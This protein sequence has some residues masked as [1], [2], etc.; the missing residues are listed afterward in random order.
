MNTLTKTLLALTLIAIAFA[1][2]GCG[3]SSGLDDHAEDSGHSESDGHNHGSTEAD[4]HSDAGD[5]HG[6]DEGSEDGHEEHGE[7]VIK[8]SPQQ[9]ERAGV[10]IQPLSGGTITT[11]ITLPAEVGL[12]LDAV[13]HVTP[14]VPG[15]VSEVSGLLGHAVVQ[16]D[17]LAI[18]ES[19]ELGEAKIAYL[20]SVQSKAIA[21]AELNRQRTI[22][23]NT[24]TLLD[25][26][27]SE[28]ELDELRAGVADLRIGENKGRLLSAYARV[29]AAE[30]NYAR[31][32]ELQKK[33]LSTESDLLAAQEA[34]NSTQADYFAAFEDIDFT[35]Q[36]RLQEAERAARVASSS[37]DN[38]ERRLHL[39]GLSHEQVAGITDD[40]DVDVA[41]YSLTAP[42][43][44]RIIAKHITPGE[45]VGTDETVYT[46]ANLDTVW[47]NISVYSQY[48][49]QIT[50]GLQV[51]VHAG[52]RTTTGVVDYVSAVV[53]ESTRT[54]SAR[55]VLDN[56]DRSWKPGEFVTARVE[57]RQTPVARVVPL[58]AIQ[59]FEGQQ[60]VFVQDADGIEPVAVRLG[61]KNDVSVELVGDDIALGTPVVIRNSFLM[62]A[63]LG[64][65]AAG[66]EH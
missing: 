55:V 54:V 28:P 45:R 66:H 18:L 13:L 24:Q 10:L 47:L 37:V 40:P 42:I 56:Q 35:Y 9:L 6:H 29:R 17:L 33:S 16:G 53:S 20:Q 32:R 59:T 19:P 14:R 5:A 30:A 31:E 60:V 15:I 21:D 8:L 46:I 51:V 49:G 4:D 41:R 48:A 44:G 58:D 34:F 52:D 11:H 65:S 63:E 62:K 12:N 26:L 2:A 7:D 23:Q 50:E 43:G 57:T 39:L 22:S 3:D 38:S 36:L 25:L 1:T 27:K 61:R 64:K